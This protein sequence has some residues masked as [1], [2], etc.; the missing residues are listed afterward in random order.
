MEKKTPVSYGTT[1]QIE[2]NYPLWSLNFVLV[3]SPF[4]TCLFY[5]MHN[6]SNLVLPGAKQKKRRNI[7]YI[8]I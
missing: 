4:L 3:H 1:L 7:E 8:L 2:C 5:H 6:E